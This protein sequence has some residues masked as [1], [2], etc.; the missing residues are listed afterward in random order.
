[1]SQSMES[2]LAPGA[3]GQGRGA[4]D[5]RAARDETQVLVETS[6]ALPLVS[7]VVAFRSGAAHDPPGREGLA[8]I[9]ARMLRRGAEGY[10]ANQIEETIDAL[11][12]ELGADVATSATT[13]HLEVIKRSLDRFI[14]LGA[15]LLARPTF[16]EAELSRLLREAEAELIEAR[17]SDRSLC[18]RAFRRTL[19]AGHPY[20]RRIAGTI[21]TLRAISRDDVA[22]FYA[23]HY[24]R[25]NAVVA[26]SGDIEP[27]EARAIAERLLA[28]LPEG[29]VIPDPVRD[30]EPR[31]GR[32]LVIVDKP[33]RT[34]T[35][36]VIGGLGTD[37]HDPD[38][39]ALVVANTAFGGTFSSRLMQEVRVKRG[40]SYGAYSR[41][42][43]DRHR[44]AFT[45]WA[46]PSAQ[47]AAACLALE[48][49]LL[50]GLRHQGITQ[51]E[52]T[53]VQRYL[54]RSHAFEIDT[55]RKRVHQKLDE[56]LYDLPE[57]YHDE[58]LKRVEAVTLA[59][60]N[61]A[62]QRRLSEDD[63]VISVVGTHAEIGAAIEKAIPGLADV[64]VEPYD[65]E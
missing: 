64:A 51:D 63:L 65:L 58:Y 5:G 13:V 57:G 35:Q 50:H 2:G 20:G 34:Q 11:G 17:D 33:D 26:V 1:M 46:A 37:A 3:G 27:D 56:A 24:T 30:P 9:T 55:A 19:F 44:D 25:R 38:H 4:T 28:G 52:L 48:L 39:F 53:F 62:V 61:A 54:V 32:R 8:R 36:M 42:G 59:E 47:D 41:V 60:A 6:H 23:R 14:D 12:G 22:A 29:E 21:P 15:T 16:P 10:S 49:E 7:I 40:W 18:S 45:M 31:P 43:F